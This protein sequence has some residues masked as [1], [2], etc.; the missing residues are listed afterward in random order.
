MKTKHE[1]Q[2]VL[3][4]SLIGALF[5][6]L[7]VLIFRTLLPEPNPKETPS[8][9]FPMTDAQ[10]ISI[11]DSLASTTAS[12]T[13]AAKAYLK[14]NKIKVDPKI[15]PRLQVLNNLAKPAKPAKGAT[16]TP[17]LTDAQKL[18]KLNALKSQ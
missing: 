13:D 11:L 6:L 8:A 2:H 17:A 3:A 7:A 9:T 10:K 18:E 15:D 4:Y 16:A 1:R 12:S 5:A 14:E